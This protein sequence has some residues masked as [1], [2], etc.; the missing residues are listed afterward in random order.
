MK[1]N[2]QHQIMWDILTITVY[3]IY[4]AGFYFRESGA[5]REFNNTRK[6]LPPIRTH[7]CDL[8]YLT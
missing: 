4:F 2:F 1:L 7:E 6:Y 8:T 5:S 3:A